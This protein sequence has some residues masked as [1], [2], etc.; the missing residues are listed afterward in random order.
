MRILLIHGRSQGGKNPE[1]LKQTWIDTL[2][3]GFETA[4]DSIPDDVAFDFPFYGDKLDELTAQA[5]LPTSEDVVTKGVGQNDE[6]EEFLHS[7]LAEF[8]AKGKVSPQEV[9]AAYEA[10][11]P[12]LKG[13]QEK[14]PQNWGWVQ[15]IA[16]ALDKHLTGVA[17]FTIERYLKDVFLYV[18]NR[19][20]QRAVDK[21]VEAELTGEPTIAVGHSLGSVVGFNVLRAKRHDMSLS[22]YL[23]VGSP[24]GI[25]AISSKLGVIENPAPSWYNAYDERDV[26]ALN[27]LDATTFDVR[28]RI[29]NNNGVTNHTD[30]RHGID[31]YLNDAEVAKQIAASLT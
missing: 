25:T 17:D 9:D 16:R 29:V 28:P 31:G 19:N 14:G 22:K 24:L 5:D 6:F 3:K 18:N 13:T 11:D 7:A 4:G 21:I 23:T 15:A 20:V 30:N 26:V 8:A 27:P 10:L 1:T 12:E 2:K